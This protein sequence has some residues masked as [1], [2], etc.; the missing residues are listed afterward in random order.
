MEVAQAT[1]VQLHRQGEQLRVVEENLDQVRGWGGAGSWLPLPVVLDLRVVEQLLRCCCCGQ[2]HG[3]AILTAPARPF[4]L[5][6]AP[7]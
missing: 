6:A 7:R 4:S 1:T 2:Q 5:P 3:A